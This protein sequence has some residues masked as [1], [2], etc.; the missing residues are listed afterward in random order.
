MSGVELRHLRYFVAVAEELHF[1]RAAQRLAMAQ[2]PLSTQIRRLEAELGTDLLRRTTRRVE[3]TEAGRAYL[4][5]AR[6]VLDAVAAAE[7][8]ARR[9][10]SGLQGSLVVGCVGSATYT[11]LPR[12][13]RTLR[14]RL[15]SV[16]VAFRGEMLVPDQVEALAEGRMDIGLL[17]PPPAE[18]WLDLC[19]LRRDPLVVLA[20]AGHP[21]TA[22]RR[23]TVQDLRTAELV[24]H[25]GARG[26]SMHALVVGMCA[27]AG[28]DAPIAHEVV[29]TS[30][31]VTFVAAGLGVAV[32]PEPAAAL[33]LPGVVALPFLGPGDEPVS[34]E[35]TAATRAADRS[36]LVDRALA[37]L[38]ELAGGAD[39]IG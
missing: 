37:V 20:P 5:R 39:R 28:F 35:L 13:A 6:A 3:L 14:D 10:G 23:V 16:A 22:R 17:R 30:T 33:A 15:P 4:H 8:E 38:R 9:I 24:A 27:E 18:P 1:G 7:A 2:P 25:A 12:F 31:M 36:P 19:P 32:V 11:L 21:F 29:E 26:S 34:I